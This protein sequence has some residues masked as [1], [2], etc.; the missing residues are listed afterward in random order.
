ML[1][2]NVANFFLGLE[3]STGLPLWVI[4]A[5]SIVSFIFLMIYVILIPITAISIGNNLCSLN[6]VIQAAKQETK[7]NF[8]AQLYKY[9]LL[10][11]GRNSVNSLLVP[12]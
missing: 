12:P 11:R 4:L 5:I 8:Q 9:N 7:R 1:I 3:Q 6:Q 10:K 2:E